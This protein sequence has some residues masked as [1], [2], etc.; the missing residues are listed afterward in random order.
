MTVNESQVCRTQSKRVK[1]K[2]VLFPLSGSVPLPTKTQGNPGLC[3]AEPV[4]KQA[5]WNIQQQ[6]EED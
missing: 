6:I 5:V 2:K 3:N 4:S 1:R